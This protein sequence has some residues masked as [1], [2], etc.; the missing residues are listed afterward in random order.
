VKSETDCV[1]ADEVLPAKFALL[2]A[3]TATT[4][5]LPAANELVE[6]FAVPLDRLTEAAGVLLPSK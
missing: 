6:N 4:A 3:N 1:R 5:W 2:E